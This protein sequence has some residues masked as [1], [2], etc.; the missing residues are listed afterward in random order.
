MS[1]SRLR[2]LCEDEWPFMGVG[3]PPEGTMDLNIV[4]AVY[5][6]VTG[7]P[8]HPD[9]IPY[10][11]SW[12]GLAQHPPP[13][14]R[15]CIPKG[16]GKLFMAQKLTDDEKDSTGFGGNDL[17]P[18]SYW[19]MMMHAPPSAPP[20]P[21]SALMPDPGPAEIPATAAARPP[22][23]QKIIEL[24]FRQAPIPA[25]GASGHRP[26]HSTPARPPRLYLPVPV[27]RNK[28]GEGNTGIR[29][30]LHSAQEHRVKTPTAAAPQRGTTAPGP[31]RRWTLPPASCNL[32]SSIYILNWQRHTPPYSGEPQG[33]IR[34]VETIFF[35]PTA[36]HGM[37]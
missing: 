21:E 23:P 32:F 20:G 14:T 11:D 7:N 9:Q 27:S 22:A 26:Q 4:Q 8:G 34:L 10:I 24:P 17:A 30:R 5:A 16:K 28:K 31:G 2:A 37:T 29:Q 36:L 6:V 35:K 15:F 18:P 1:P 13:W 25:E 12:L 3:W 33:M 19:M